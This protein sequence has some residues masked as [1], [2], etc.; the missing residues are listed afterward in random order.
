[1]LEMKNDDST[2]PWGHYEIL[3]DT[4]YCKVKRIYVKPEQ[5]LSYQYHHKRQE[6]WTVVSGVARITVDDDTNDFGP[7]ETVLIP[8][9]AKHRM[10]NPKKDQDMILIEVQTGTYFGEDDIVRVQDDYDR[11][12]SHDTINLWK[13]KWDITKD[14]ESSN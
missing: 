13:P 5:R 14:E 7:G 3:L 1:M 2:R 4:K 11:P 9:G 10:A 12:E 8:L 6:A